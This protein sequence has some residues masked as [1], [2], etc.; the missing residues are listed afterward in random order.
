MYSYYSLSSQEI[1]VRGN[2]PH[3]YFLTGKRDFHKKIKTKRYYGGRSP[4]QY[5][6]VLIFYK[7]RKVALR[8]TFLLL[9]VLSDHAKNTGKNNLR[10]PNDTPKSK[11]RIK[12][13]CT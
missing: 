2:P 5:L 3:C 7:R 11:C 10:V 12:N 4:P 13:N 8:A 9:L 6:L 1:A